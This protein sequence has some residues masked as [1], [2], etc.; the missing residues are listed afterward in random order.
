[1]GHPIR[2]ALEGHRVPL[3][4]LLTPHG[5]HFAVHQHLALL[6]DHLGLAAGL[7]QGP[8]LQKILELDVF[9]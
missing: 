2:L 7:R 8:E 5:A 6:D 3:P 4:E 1:M 9:R